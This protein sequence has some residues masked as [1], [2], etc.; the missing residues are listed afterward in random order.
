MMFITVY[1]TGQITEVQFTGFSVEYSVKIFG[2]TI[3]VLC[4][5][6]SDTGKLKNDDFV[7]LKIKCDNFTILDG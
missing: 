4:L 5:S 6:S 3:K 7:T 2:M 1:R